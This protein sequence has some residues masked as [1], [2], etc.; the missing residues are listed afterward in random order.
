MTN[1]AIFLDKDGTLIEDVP[2]NVDPTKIRFLPGALEAVKRLHQDGFQIFIISN[3]SGVARG[4]FKEEDLKKVEQHIRNK[5]AEVGVPLAGFYYCPHY[6]EGKVEAYAVTCICRKPRPGLLFKAA[7]EHDINLDK[8]WMIG[9][10][11]DDVEA[12]RRAECST[13]LLNNGNET[14]WTLTPYRRPHY[15]AKNLSEAVSIIVSSDGNAPTDRKP[16]STAT[17]LHKNQIGVSL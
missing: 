14:E 17:R 9:D 16:A 6:P 2:Y 4:F 5:M 8:S 7:R 15:A 11:L 12:G 13:I 1:K 3:Q 10:I